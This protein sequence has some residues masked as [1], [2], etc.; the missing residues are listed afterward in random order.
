MWSRISSTKKQ[1]NLNTAPG[2][3]DP[4]R[5]TRVRQSM[6]AV[7]LLRQTQ[8]PC[9]VHAAPAACA[10]CPHLHPGERGAFDHHAV[11]HRE[12]ASVNSL[13]DPK[14]DCP[15]C[16]TPPAP[17]AHQLRHT[18]EWCTHKHQFDDFPMNGLIDMNLAC[19]SSP[20]SAHLARISSEAIWSSQKRRRC[21]R[22]VC[23][24]R[25]SGRSLFEASA[26]SFRSS[27]ISVGS[28]TGLLAGTAAG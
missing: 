25:F 20:S 3:C 26:S 27:R 11:T 5:L 2:R 9:A 15:G 10:A 18:S 22:R 13:T 8:C 24:L 4:S 19:V 7:P 23:S 12:T 17:I 28:M 21:C 6:A 16:N 14:D 1:R